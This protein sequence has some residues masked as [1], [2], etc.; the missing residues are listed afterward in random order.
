SSWEPIAPDDNLTFGFRDSGPPRETLAHG[1]DLAELYKMAPHASPAR[2]TT[3]GFTLHLM[4]VF[5][6]PKADGTF[7]QRTPGLGTSHEYRI[8]AVDFIGRSKDPAL[9]SAWTTSRR[10]QLQKRTPPPQPVG[11]VATE[12]PAPGEIVRSGVQA[13][14]IVD[15]PDLTPEDQARLVDASN[16]KHNNAVVLR[17]G[18]RN[19]VRDNDGSKANGGERERDPF[20]KE[21]RVYSLARPPIAV[22]GQIT[23]VKVHADQIQLAFTQ[24][25]GEAW[26]R[27]NECAG[28]WLPSGGYEF[29]I[30]KHDEVKADGQPIALF[31]LKSSKDPGREPVKNERV[32]FGRPLTRHHLRSYFW[33]RR[34]A[35][36][37]LHADP[38]DENYEV[39]LYDLFDLS[40][41]RPKQTIW[42]GV[43]AA[44]AEPYIPDDVRQARD[45]SLLNRPGNESVVATAS[46]TATYTVR[47][48]L[49][50]PPPLDTLPEVL[51]NE[52][53]GEQTSA[54]L[55]LSKWLGTSLRAG[56]TVHVERCDADTIV[57]VLSVQGTRPSF[58][59]RIFH[60]GT[61]HPV[62]LDPLGPG[63]QSAIFDALSTGQ[64]SKLA[65]KYLLWL[66]YRH[67]KPDALW[68]TLPHGR[69]IPYG[70]F[71]DY[72]PAKPGRH[73]YRIR[74]VD[75]AGRVSEGA[76]YVPGAVRV[77]RLAAPPS[78]DRE[79][80]KAERAASGS[81]STTLTV[82]FPNDDD[83]SHVL[84]FQLKKPYDP[85][86]PLEERKPIPSASAE[87][88]RVPNRVDLY[89]Q[90]KAIRLRSEG[91]IVGPTSVRPVAGNPDAKVDDDGQRISVT[92]R[93]EHDKEKDAG[94]FVQSYCCTLSKD[95][96]PSA[97][98]GPFGVFLPL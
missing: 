65:A 37:P 75:A 3:T 17:F 46:I 12:A 2:E 84:L 39:T 50:V 81:L 97:P 98:A 67:P 64:T 38:N 83:I 11:P 96:I 13:R 16:R 5:D 23:P 72:L 36:V 57:N 78:P 77:P 89:T 43:T 1:S 91:T 59:L 32:V 9:D 95:G 29:Q 24:S 71:V 93:A 61:F 18:W 33:D 27:Q 92:L 51:A 69:S 88:L 30:V 22:S 15:G 20:T 47:P 90:G 58:T 7:E 54:T 80:L 48:A 35:V 55:P 44:D 73:L 42:V 14:V 25:S 45:P 63:D 31:V 94:A 74:R 21:F 82:S 19:A 56:E 79:A 66:A 40:P 26:L 76:A 4:D 6:R 85:A 70:S 41:E 60:E 52:P 34:E 86:E 87:L 28:E 49:N 68:N 8:L 62:A 53:T 10:V